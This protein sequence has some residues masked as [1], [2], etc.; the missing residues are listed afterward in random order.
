MAD[1]CN[2]DCVSDRERAINNEG[3]LA[4]LEEKVDAINNKLDDAIIGNL[5]DHGKRIASLERSRAWMLGAS[6]V[7]GGLV[8]LLARLF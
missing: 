6:A 3:R 1:N 8:S 7:S 4:R 2:R 5:R